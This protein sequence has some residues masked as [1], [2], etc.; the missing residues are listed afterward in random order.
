MEAGRWRVYNDA[1]AF[2]FAIAVVVSSRVRILQK[3]AGHARVFENKLSRCLSCVS[4][5]VVKVRRRARKRNPVLFTF[6]TQREEAHATLS[7]SIYTHVQ[8]QSGLSALCA[9]LLS[10]DR[11]PRHLS[12]YIS[13]TAAKRARHLVKYRRVAGCHGTRWSCWACVLPWVV[14]ALGVRLSSTLR[15]RTGF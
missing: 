7:C 5:R 9:L 1:C 13:A 8:L 14:Q 3:W 15:A 6:G 10:A 2:L 4:V 11:L 12:R